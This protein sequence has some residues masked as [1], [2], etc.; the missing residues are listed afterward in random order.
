MR[1][2]SLK[3]K[4]VSP[5]GGIQG[6]KILVEGS[7]FDPDAI[8]D[9]RVL[10]GD[11]AGRILMMSGS[12]ILAQIPDEAVSGEI[13]IQAGGKKSNVSS[14]SL[15]QK[16]AGN[17]QP[18]DNPVY[19]SKGNLYATFSGKRGETVPVSVFRISPEGEIKPHLSNIPNATSM[20]FDSAG[21]LYVSSRFEGSVY[22]ATPSADISVFAKE[23]GTPTGLAFD[24]RGNLFVGDRGGKILKITP[25]AKV[26]VFAEVP[27]SMVAFHL[28]FD[29]DGNLLVS[30]PGMSSSNQVILIDRLGKS[31]PLCSGF[32]RPQGIATDGDG[33]VYVCEAKA[34]D[35]GVIRIS[36]DGTARMMV[37][38]PVVVGVALDGNGTLAVASQDAVYT[39]PLPPQ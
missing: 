10:F 35:S 23:L 25:D 3:I 32:G 16:L 36:P 27:E 29:K 38:G 18:V 39:L 8:A 37:T 1:A 22:R 17:L 15:A 9:T 30:N 4:A 34:G 21:N 31:G 5:P 7:G 20:A 26:T 12:R 19:D 2:R 11:L 14:F 6:G 24:S 28:A 13:S 33:N